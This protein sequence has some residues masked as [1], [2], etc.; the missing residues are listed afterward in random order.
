MIRIYGDKS[1]AERSNYKCLNSIQEIKRY[2]RLSVFPMDFDDTDLMILKTIDNAERIGDGVIKTPF[3]LT[4]KEHITS[5][6][7]IALIINYWIKNNIGNVAIRVTS[8]GPNALNIVYELANN[9]NIALIQKPMF[10]RGANTSH[11][12]VYND[13]EY[14]G[15]FD[16]FKDL[17]L[18]LSLRPDEE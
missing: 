3:G 17:L 14:E 15:N 12:I 6:S 13:G 1:D 2:F 10:M 16:G 18:D 9:K 8:C 5:G 4:T 7:T 11:D